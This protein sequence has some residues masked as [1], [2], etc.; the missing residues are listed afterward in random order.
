LIWQ[1]SIHSHCFFFGSPNHIIWD[2]EMFF[3][4][5]IDDLFGRTIKI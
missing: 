4:F 3:I 5:L 1:N 2:F